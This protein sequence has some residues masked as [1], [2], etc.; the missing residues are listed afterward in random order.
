MSTNNKEYTKVNLHNKYYFRRKKL[1]KLKKENCVYLIDMK[2]KEIPMIKVCNSIDI[3]KRVSEFRSYN[4]LCE[5]LFVIYTNTDNSVLTKQCAKI[6]Y[7]KFL[8]NECIKGV[9]I[10]ELKN[11]LL[12]FMKC[13]NS[14][15][16][17]ESE[18]EID[19]FNKHIIKD[20]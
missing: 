16:T 19:K 15:Y 5:V 6:K 3:T 9:D 12:S 18:E 4:P 7:A 1:Y 20:N 17:V 2:N 8:D 11:F 13:I 10:E 14:T